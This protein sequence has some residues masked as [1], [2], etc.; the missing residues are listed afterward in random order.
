MISNNRDSENICVPRFLEEF[1]KFTDIDLFNMDILW[2]YVVL[3]I[4][5][6]WNADFVGEKIKLFP[7]RKLLLTLA[8]KICRGN[9]FQDYCTSMYRACIC[10]NHRRVVTPYKVVTERLHP[11]QKCPRKLRFRTNL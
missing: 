1:A 3:Y 10:T 2:P 5:Y 6:L 7:S 4:E 8:Q 9:I 11:P